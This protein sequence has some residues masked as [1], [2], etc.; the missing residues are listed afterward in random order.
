[1]APPLEPAVKRKRSEDAEAE[2][3]ASNAAKYSKVEVVK[4]EEAEAPAAEEDVAIKQE[5]ME[6]SEV[7]STTPTATAA[8]AP[9]SG[10]TRRGRGRPQNRNSAS[11][12]AVTSTRS[13]RLSKAGSPGVIGQTPPAQEPA[14]PPKR[15][16]VGSSTRKT[17]SA[18]SL[19]TSSQGGTAA[20]EDSKDSMASSMD[21]LLLAAADIKQ[22]KLTAEFEDSLLL[23]E[24]SLPSTSTGA[25]S[26]T[27]VASSGSNGHSCIEP[28]TVETDPAKPKHLLPPPED[29]TSAIRPSGEAATGAAA[30]GVVGKAPS[31]SPEMVS[32]GVSAVSVRNFYKKPEFLANNLG[33]EKDPELGEIVQTVSSNATES[34]EMVV[35]DVQSPKLDT[36]KSASEAAK[37]KDQAEEAEP[38]TEILAEALAEITAE[39]EDS[40]S[41][42]SMK[43]GDLR[44]DD[45]G[46]GSEVLLDHGLLL[47]G[48]GQQE[49][50]QPEAEGEEDPDVRQTKPNSY[51]DSDHEIMD[52]LVQEGVLDASGNPL[53]QAGVAKLE[54]EL[55]EDIGTGEVVAAIVNQY[56]LGITEQ[57]EQLLVD[58]VEYP[59]EN[60]ENLS[61][62]AG[63]TAPDGL[64]IQLALKDEDDEELPVKDEEQVKH[65]DLELQLTEK[66]D[67]DQ[68][69][70]D[71]ELDEKPSN[72]KQEEDDE[73]Q[74]QQRREQEIHLQNLG[75]LTLQAAEQR[76]QDLQEAHTRQAQLQQQQQHQHH[77]HHQH[78][79]QGA[80]GGGGGGGSGASSATHVESS[81]TLKTV[82]KLNRSSNGGVGG[83]SGLPT[84]TVIHGSGGGGASGS[85]ASS[86]SSS[87]VGSATRKSS[88]ALGGS[89][90]GGATGAGA[91]VRRQSL[92]MT[93]QKGRAR[94]HGAA[95]RSADQPT[96][97]SYYT[98][99]N[100]VSV[101]GHT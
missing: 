17:A 100:E 99:Q 3:E 81:G 1:M 80:R 38:E 82:I 27:V 59:E 50:G 47:N 64:D 6:A 69:E 8:P 21:D 9:I 67:V 28:L 92:K 87:S 26:A 94:G 53:S 95:D 58:K 70:P 90:A 44:L 16:R 41:L 54:E 7:V 68:E 76:R 29:A 30:S 97:D 83:S 56:I 57:A 78:K 10:G 49:Q 36:K 31:L 15:R 48:A 93:F 20:D 84:G 40:I 2:A 74:Q 86:S 52:K 60:K 4:T 45:S 24:T 91:G 79:R 88:G 77:H 39:A 37:I 12:A 11:P 51:E 35:E 75:L 43:T 55:E 34:E 85:A 18:S 72:G 98:I 63:A 42:G 5:P 71:E 32:E 13:T 61:T 19:A 46:E 23:A 73:E 14:A 33:I 65:L 62:A 96:E 101:P 22:E 89:G 66:M 25:P